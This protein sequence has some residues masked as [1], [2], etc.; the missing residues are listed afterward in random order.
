M[1]HEINQYHEVLSI[2]RENRSKENIN[3]FNFEKL[4]LIRDVYKNKLPICKYCLNDSDGL[5]FPPKSGGVYRCRCSLGEKS[6]YERYLILSD[7][8]MKEWEK[9]D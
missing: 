5:A 4:K 1:N 8:E 3:V 7:M 9:S 2:Y 6:K